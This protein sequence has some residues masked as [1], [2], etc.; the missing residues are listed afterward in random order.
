VLR[1]I[2][3]L[4]SLIS[5]NGRLARHPAA[6]LVALA[7]VHGL[8]YAWLVPPWQ[9]PDEPTQFEYAALISR[10][11]FIPAATDSDPQLEREIA[12][13]LVRQH[14]FEYLLGHPP[15]AA[16]QSLDDVRALFFMPRQV[17]N[18]PPLYF[19]I[20]ALPIRALAGHPIEAQLMALRLLGVLLIAGAALCAYG[21]G[22][23][24]CAG[25]PQ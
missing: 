24:L 5:K 11:G 9:A 12:A 16:P 22:R 19:V 13:S 14:F 6:L 23:E 21:A 2:A 15:A 8:L 1:S 20:A 4:Q 10:L 3:N 25:Q 17:G 7:L 18:D